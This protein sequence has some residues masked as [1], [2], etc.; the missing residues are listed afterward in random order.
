MLTNQQFLTLR[1]C[2]Q[3][4][5]TQRTIAEDTDISLGAVNAALKQLNE[6]G[7]V[8]ES[9]KVTMRGH[10]AL[11]PYK[12]ENAVIM[13]AGLSSRFAPISYEKPKGVLRV[14]GEVLIERQ[15]KQ[16]QEVGITDITVVVGYKK[17]EFFYL[18]DKFGVRIVINEEYASRNNNSTIRCVQN[19]LGNTYVCS[20][21]NYF[22][23]NP[24]ERYVYRA[25]YSAVFE[26][27]ETDE[28]CL[29]TKGKDNL[30]TGVSIGG[31]NSWV[32]L[33]H[34]YWDKAFSNKFSQILDDIYD[35]PE[36][37]GKLWED[38]YID[39]ISQLP[40]VMRKY[41]HGVIMEF[42]SLDELNDFDPEFINN[43][44]SDILD[45]ICRVL[46]CS[47]TDICGIAPIK[48]GLTNLSFKFEVGNNK[49]VYRHPGAGTDSIINR[50]SETE[51]NKIGHELGLDNTYVHEDP[52]LGWKISHFIDN[53]KTL[54]YHDWSQV[55]QAISMGRKL[56]GC[57]K[58]TGYS[59][60]VYE[61]SLE[62]VDMLDA[63]HRTS[64]REFNN[65]LALMEELY[66]KAQK[67]GARRCLC[68]CDFYDPNFLI[69]DEGQ[70]QLIDW[71][72]S[73]MSDYAVDLGTFVCCS[74]DYTTED[75]Q[76][77]FSIYFQRELTP[78]EQFHCVTYVALAGFYWF[79]W[80]LYK[81][82]CGDPVG[83]YLYL[84]YKYA[85]RYGQWAK[86]I[87]EEQGY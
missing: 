3:S 58:D 5:M 33:G 87:A 65:L 41:P 67:H 64:F 22:T 44:G 2:L 40:M 9:N 48:Q 32:M 77:V 69:D 30:I 80:A 36:T 59:Y 23:Q 63:R 14:R 38:I 1:S 82:A 51:S 49:Y 54:D 61:N 19:V 28:Y 86:Q 47:R 52:E 85:K 35:R 21:D 7:L 81:D 25:Y 70:M 37:A 17:E 12:V 50:L 75:A 13:A 18:E 66:Q 73:G 20:S 6:M 46:N 84:W 45:N 68:H 55:E 10:Q 43:V 76:R 56:H 72:Y 34:V 60:D 31:E 39:H 79:V 53:C 42:D 27:G 24:F 15:I 62:I 11:K 4:G 16:L 57:G 8:D 78:E 71:E 74:D 83:E 26:E 29:Q